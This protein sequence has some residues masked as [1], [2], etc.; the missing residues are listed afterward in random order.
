MP[1]AVVSSF[2][3]MW[4]ELGTGSFLKQCWMLLSEGA[5]ILGQVEEQSSRRKSTAFSPNQRYFLW[6]HDG[7]IWQYFLR[8]VRQP[9]LRFTCMN[10]FF[11][12]CQWFYMVAFICTVHCV[13]ALQV[14]IKD[15]SLVLTPSHIKAYMLMTLQGLEYLHQHWIL[16]RVRF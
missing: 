6:L 11:Y 7:E 4:I 5:I 1:Q 14:I 2:F 9:F 12:M 16:H 8:R 15:N 10:T 3:T 13:P